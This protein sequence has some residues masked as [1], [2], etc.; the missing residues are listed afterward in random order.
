MNLDQQLESLQRLC[1]CCGV[2]PFSEPF[3]LFCPNIELADLGEG[4]VLFFK[5]MIYFGF[6]AIVFYGINLYKVVV[7]LQGH[8]C[9]NIS[10]ISGSDLQSYTKE[11]LPPCHN[12]WVNPHSIANYGLNTVDVTE[13]SLMVAFLG[14]FWLSMGFIYSKVMDI[15]QEIDEANDTPSDWTLMVK[16][17]PTSE[18]E[19]SIA[20]NLL[21]DYDLKASKDIKIK[22]VCLAFDLKEYIALSTKVNQKKQQVKKMHYAELRTKTLASMIELPDLKANSSTPDFYQNAQ[23]NFDF[24]QIQNQG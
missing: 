22:K 24:I 7:N 13:R 18:D 17:L 14:L 4:Y 23:S 8:H 9:S 2:D 12:D 20:L 16:N 6:V 21:R 11:K 10:P 19:A 5:L 3:S 1:P 15:C